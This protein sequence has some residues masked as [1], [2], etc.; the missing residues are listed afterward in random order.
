MCHR[1]V[2]PARQQHCSCTA[3]SCRPPYV[4]LSPPRVSVAIYL[5]GHGCWA[6]KVVVA[7]T[8]DWV[9]P[10]LLPQTL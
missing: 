8:I 7:P 1:F 3:G 2:V 6:N 9:C 10:R 5:A 4:L